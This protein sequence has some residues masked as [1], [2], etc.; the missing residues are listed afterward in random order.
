MIAVDQLNREQLIEL[1]E[2]TEKYADEAEEKFYLYEPNSDVIVKFH[3]SKARVR[4]L[5]SGN[6]GG[7]TTALCIEAII[8]ATGE[9]P[10]SL[11]K[12][13][14]KEKIKVPTIARL[15][16]VDYDNGV[17]KI[18]QPEIEK[19]LPKKYFGSS[20]VDPPVL[21][22]QN[23]SIFE[24]MSYD[25]KVSKFGGTSRHFI[26][27]D[28]IPPPDAIKENQM[29]IADC[30]GFMVFAFTPVILEKDFT[31]NKVTS[32]A[33]AISYFY[34]N[35]YTKAGRVVTPQADVVNENGIP[36]IEMFHIDVFDNVHIDREAL[37]EV[38]ES[39]TEEE[40]AARV[41]GL[42]THLA[43]LV[44]GPEYDEK[45][46][47]IK[48]YKH[49]CAWPVYVAIDPHPSTP[50][51]VTYMTVDPHSRKIV[52]DELVVKGQ[53]GDLRDA[54]R[55]TEESKGYWVIRRLIDPS[56]N[57]RD[58][59]TKTCFAQELR[60]LDIHTIAGS[61][62]KWTGIVKVKEALK[63]KELF[64][65]DSCMGH[66]WEITNYV[67]R[68]DEPIDS[69]DH[70]MENLRRLILN[71]PGWLDKDVYSETIKRKPRWLLL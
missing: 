50:H 65:A 20:T 68:G 55:T 34:Q 22:L 31:S 21:Y 11:Q 63:N 59:I 48:D 18:V 8:A 44:Y 40:R 57:N 4:G 41:H 67:W 27:F 5:I 71:K 62:D 51:H 19:W 35:F 14:P 60:H 43:G 28:E 46:H 37:K 56:A 1:L 12:I 15:L 32:N 53:A 7:K 13:Y 38:A 52:C 23:N 54:M 45:V 70:F 17:K 2:L 16:A 6:R 61:K 39:L 49:D 24:F 47:V 3:A 26:G 10:P 42:F 33:A 58:Q 25:Q 30:G 69:N 64:F 9:V 29:R 66:R 36:W